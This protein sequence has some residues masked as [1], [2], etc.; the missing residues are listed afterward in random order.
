M[1]NKKKVVCYRRM[2]NKARRFCRSVYVVHNS[3]QG[4]VHA[5]LSRAIFMQKMTKETIKA[6]ITYLFLVRLRF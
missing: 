4:Q 6:H 1:K 3:T 2:V 5:R